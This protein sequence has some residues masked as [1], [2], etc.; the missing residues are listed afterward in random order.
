M[1]CT[2]D[3]LS[4]PADT[5]VSKL[6]TTAPVAASLTNT[7]RGPDAP[8]GTTR[9]ATRAPLADMLGRRYWRWLESSG[10]RRTLVFAGTSTRKTCG[11][12]EPASATRF[13]AVDVNAIAS[14]SPLIAGS[15]DGWSPAAP[16]AL[17]LTRMIPPVVRSR[18]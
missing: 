5:A 13:V 10:D 9:Y 3:A 8:G 17:A 1:T 18:R 4:V 12:A 14:P 6:A 7:N 2:P 16:A 15:A 11:C